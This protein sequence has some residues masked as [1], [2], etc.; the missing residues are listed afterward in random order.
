MHSPFAGVCHAWLIALG[1]CQPAAVDTAGLTTLFLLH[2][3]S[4]PKVNMG[5]EGIQQTR[6]SCGDFFAGR[7]QNHSPQFQTFKVETSLPRFVRPGVP[8]RGEQH[9]KKK[10]K[11]FKSYMKVLQD[12]LMR[13]FRNSY[14]INIPPTKLKKS[15]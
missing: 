2:P 12:P 10:K 1:G 4:L 11:A 5:A 14:D 8:L 9:T 3:T 15:V 13:N 6:H 7:G